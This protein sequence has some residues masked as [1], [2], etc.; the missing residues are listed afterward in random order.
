MMEA[1]SLS[2]NSGFVVALIIMSAMCVTGNMFSDT[3]P[4]PETFG[5]CPDTTLPKSCPEY[6]PEILQWGLITGTATFMVLINRRYNFIPSL[7]TIHASV[8]LILTG[9]D[10]W[11]DSFL[12]FSTLLAAANLFAIASIF[13]A[14]RSHQPKKEGTEA[15]FLIA[16]VFAT[17]AIFNHAFLFFIPFYPIAAIF[18]GLLSWK[19]IAAT[20]LGICAPY[21]IILGFSL[22]NPPSVIPPELTFPYAGFFNTTELWFI[23]LITLIASATVIILMRNSISLLS[24]GKQTRDMGHAISVLTLF[25]ILLIIVDFR[26]FHSYIPSLFMFAGFQT[27]YLT[28]F[29][30]HHGASAIFLLTLILSVSTLILIIHV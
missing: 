1:K 26:N 22:L 16:L 18:L 8:F 24:A 5:L 20:I 12:S 10:I 3:Y 14:Y 28:G 23:M 9:T 30:N 25:P 2:G 11:F 6:L 13:K 29:R 7:T 4:T 27:G 15:L 17:G 19:S 21:W